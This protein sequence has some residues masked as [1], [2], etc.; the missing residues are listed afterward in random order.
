MRNPITLVRAATK[1]ADQPHPPVP[2]VSR[3]GGLGTS[4]LTRNSEG[5][6]GAQLGAMAANSTAYAVVDVLANPTALVE[7]HLYRS[8]AS[9]RD[10]DRVEVLDHPALTLWRKPNPFMVRALFCETVNQHYELTGEGAMVLYMVGTLPVQMWPVRPDRLI[11]VPHPTQFLAGWIYTSPDGEK[12]PLTVDQVKFIRTPNPTDPYRGLSPFGSL[13]GDMDSARYATLWNRNFFINSAEPGGVLESPEVLPD[14]KFE[15]LRK[16]WHEQHRGVSAAHRVAILEGG[17]KWVDRNVSHKDMTFVELDERSVAK[18]REA[19]R[20]TKPV[21]G[22]TDDVNRANAE[23]AMVIHGLMQL[24][25]RLERW[26]QLLNFDLLPMFGEVTGRGFEFD[27]D[28]PVPEDTER[29]ANVLVAKSTAAKNLIDAGLDRAGVLEAVGLPEIAERSGVDAPPPAPVIAPTPAAEPVVDDSGPVQA[30]AERLPPPLELPRAEQAGK[31]EIDLDEVQAAWERQLEQLLAVWGPVLAGWQ[32]DLLAQIRAAIDSGKVDKL[33]RLSLDSEEAAGLVA[34]HMT[35]LAQ[36][37]AERV[38]HEAERQGVDG[39][40][41]TVPK[42]RVIDDQAAVTAGLLAAGLAIAAGREAMRVNAPDL[43]G[44]Q[45]ADKVG[46]FLAAMSD[47]TTRA[48]L[49]G[50]LT[51]AQNQARIETFRSGPIA[52][53][54]ADEKLDSNTCVNCRAID[55]RYIGSTEDGTTMAEV[56]KLYPMGGYVDCLG[57][58]RCRGTITGVWRKGGG[59]G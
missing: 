24:T 18:I 25:P 49:G 26:K 29:E 20:V 31:P 52:S 5:D 55:G 36:T 46:E 48:S 43:D 17:M 54:Y 1:P 15:T 37:A 39:L 34:E 2:Y 10:E 28:N 23:A 33:T 6:R 32:A 9:G 38:V 44:N 47:A 12:V 7:W 19:K 45:V 13:A 40:E 35:D 41:A 3:P 8:S 42:P 22:I 11:P 50:A 56:E 4:V 59:D 27:Y 58:D 14:D 30:R 21:L 57:R 53:L 16:R 51:G